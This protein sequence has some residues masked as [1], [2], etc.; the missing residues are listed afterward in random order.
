MNFNE[1]PK[2]N[3]NLIYDVGMHKGED[4]D[5]YL[6]KG[7][8]VVAFEAD[9]MLAQQCKIKFED[10]IKN[11]SLTIVEG[12]IIDFTEGNKHEKTVKFFK[13][14]TVSV[15]GTVA[16]DWAVRNE[17]MGTSTEIIEVPAINFA[18]CI[19][20]YGIP[21]Y[22]KIDIEGMDTI[23]LKALIE[24]EEKPDYISIESDKVSFEKLEIE[25]QLFQKLGYTKFKAINQSNIFDQKEPQNSKEGKYLGHKFIDG[26]SGLFGADL[27]G[28]WKNM[29]EIKVQYKKIFRRYKLYGDYGT[30]RKYLIVK[31][32]LKIINFFSS[33]QIPGWYDTHAKH[34]SVND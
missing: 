14:K 7:F 34:G 25:F 16:S 10:H 17:H 33:E 2:K 8:N 21:H 27:P 26:S 29:E 6:K 13:N 32:I 19:K 5:Y 23:C 3:K 22:L 30:L 24:F 9:P 15:W 4:T 11:G 31:A 12:A 18:D 1:S 20:K 28:S